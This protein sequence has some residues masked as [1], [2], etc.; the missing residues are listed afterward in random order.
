MKRILFV[1]LLTAGLAQASQAQKTLFNF[2]KNAAT[3]DEFTRQFYKNNPEGSITK[4]TARYYLNLF[5]NFKLKVQQA[6]DLGMDTASD[7]VSEM[8]QYKK[9]LAQPYMV[10]TSATEMLIDEAYQNSTQ[11]V[12]VSHIM[13]AIGYDALPKDTLEAYNKALDLKKKL[14]SEP[15]D[16]VA[17][18]YSEDPS[19]KNNF[20]H[21]GYFTAFDMI[22]P[23]EKAAYS[24]KVGDIAGPIRTQF[25]YHIIKVWDK[26]AWRGKMQ[27]AHI[28]VRVGENA[29]DDEILRGKQKVD[30]I[31]A[32]IKAGKATFEEMVAEYSE[33]FSNKDKGGEIGWLESTNR[34]FPE[35]FREA[36]FALKK[37]GDITPAIKTSI[38]WHLIKRLGHQGIQPKDSNYADLKRKISNPKDER[39]A[40]TKQAV[41]NRIKKEYG[42]TEEANALADFIKTDADST[43]LYGTW[44]AENHPNIKGNLF[45]IGSKKYSKAQFSKFIE[46]NQQT[47]LNQDLGMVVKDLYNSFADQQVWEYEENNLVNKYD[48]YRYLVQEYNDGILL[49]N[50]SEK[51]VW[52]KG[53]TDT[54]GL[55]E[56]YE[57]NKTRY[58][59]NDRVQAHIYECQSEDICSKVYKW[60]KKGKAD[61]TISRM[62]HEIHPLSLA[63]KTGKFEKADHPIL[64]HIKW[65]KGRQKVEVDGKHYI[66]V[67]KEV[68]PAQPK[69]LS[70]VRGP[71]TSEYQNLLEKQWIDELKSTYPVSI[72]QDTFDAFLSTLPR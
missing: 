4:D 66:I 48:K 31:A 45:T 23:F 64:S 2:G 7:F 38:G 29:K 19:A 3:L 1:L 52:N 22:Y 5:V 68:L 32:E 26:R 16:T 65:K 55:K 42:F 50:L 24:T 33:D 57:A 28:L 15:F 39:F 70:E 12:K 9:Q 35:N 40:L 51:R 41:I 10:D 60:V 72:N 20:G 46:A 54:T 43:I 11:E 14:K 71:I 67:I 25:G 47:A 58:M 49:F 44:K 13:V 36:V 37:D 62:A 18:K 30:S 17:Y 8:S 53:I 56:F 69:L 6:K 21:L 63:I 34:N 61:T 59:W 27:I